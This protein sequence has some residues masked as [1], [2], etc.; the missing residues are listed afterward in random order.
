[1]NL[2]RNIYEGWTPQD[3][4]NDLE[5]LFNMIMTNNSWQK[6]FDSKESLKE[7]CKDHQPY[8]KKHV[9]EVFNYFKNKAKL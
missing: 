8:Y 3:F 5:P 9:P 1:M 7:W 6:P 2:Q 4:I